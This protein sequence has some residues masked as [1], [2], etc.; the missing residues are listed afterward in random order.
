[1]EQSLDIYEYKQAEQ[2]ECLA[3]RN[4]IFTPVDAEQWVAM[5][6][7]A[8]TARD[9]NGLA[10]FIPLQFREQLIRPGVS[11]PVV[12]ENAVGVAEA[13]RGTGIGSK[14]MDAAADF[15]A[16]R[17]DALMVVRSGERTQG[18]RF[19]R[20]TGHSDLN[21]ALELLLPADAV[22]PRDRGHE[23]IQVDRAG[24]LSAEDDLLRLHANQYSGFGGARP[25]GRGYWEMILDSHVFKSNGR[26]SLVSKKNGVVTGYLSGIFGTWQNKE[27]LCVFELVAD[28]EDA[29]ES[30]LAVAKRLSQSGAIRFPLV[31]LANPIRPVLEKM[32]FAAGETTSH[33]MARL[34][35][36]DR[37][38]GRLAGGTGLVERVSLRVVTPHRTLIVND[39]PNSGHTVELELKEHDLARLFLCRLNLSAALDMESVR[40]KDRDPGLERELAAVFQPADWV[41][42]FS[43]YV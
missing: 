37:I 14:M 27:D 3:F 10:G 9:K 38:F 5:R 8:V 29:I 21:Y 6:C 33:L 35:R 2:D 26:K 30:L 1:M 41:Q 42:W 31:S 19:Y 34:L 40:W 16:D 11:I 23:V 39:V 13:R 28:D 20:R 24:W 17:A 22:E 15:M 43:D 32:N 36:P 7:T 18:Y 25:R 4:N 12:Y